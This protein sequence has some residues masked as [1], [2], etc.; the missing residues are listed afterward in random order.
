MQLTKKEIEDYISVL[1]NALMCESESI[2]PIMTRDWANSFPDKAGVYIF[3]I[4]NELCYVGETGSIKGR[5][6]DV[7]N[8]KNHNLRRIIGETQFQ[9]HPEYSKASSFK[10][11]V[12]E[13]ELGI[14]EYFKRKLNIS[15]IVVEL[16]R[17]ELEEYLFEKY[18]PRYNQK[19]KRGKEKAYTINEKQ[20]KHK[21]AYEPWSNEDDEN[22][23]NLHH[24][25]K[26]INEL[27]AIFERNHGAIRSRLKKLLNGNP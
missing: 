6:M 11:F 10:S 13:I 15:F 17:K 27:S 16:G 25:G 8:T 26:S 22:L 21:N 23:K 20:A 3:R 4:K 7:L 19:G 1:E 9:S 24:S 14:N 12:M 5:M 18:Q 2:C